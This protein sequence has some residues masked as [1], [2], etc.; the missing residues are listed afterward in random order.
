M[1]AFIVISADNRLHFLVDGIEKCRPRNPDV[2]TYISTGKI[3]CSESGEYTYSYTISGEVEK[4]EGKVSLAK[5]LSNQ[6]ARFRKVCSISKEE[7]VNVFLLENPLNEG[8]LEQ[9]KHWC[10]EFENIYEEGQGKDT[11]FRLFR[12]LFT[13]DVKN[14][15]D[16]TAQMRASLLKEILDNHHS[17]INEVNQGV[18]K[19]FDQFIFYIDNQNSDAAALC[20]DKDDHNL[21]MPR[22]LIDIMMLISNQNDSYG[23]MQAISNSCSTRCFAVGYAESMYYYPDVVRYFKIADYR[24][25][26]LKFLTGEDDKKDDNSRSIMD[27]NRFP[28]GVRER[29][30]R[31]G[32]LY[33]DVSFDENIDSYP[34]SADKAIDD[35]LVALKKE[36]KSERKKEYEDF[37]NSLP[38][39]ELKGEI[40][41]IQEQLKEMH[42]KGDESVS[43]FEDR[44]GELKT[45]LEKESSEL[46]K[47]RKEFAPQCPEYIDRKSILVGLGID[48]S[49]DEV[50]REKSSDYWKLVNYACSKHFLDYMESMEEDKGCSEPPISSEPATTTSSTSSSVK[51]NRRGCLGWLFFWKKENSLN[52][53]DM[54]KTSLV[55]EEKHVET[56]IDDKSL[57]L[58]IKDM[59]KC[60]KAFLNF[61][62]QVDNMEEEYL[63]NKKA[64]EE[65]ELTK[66]S[67]SYWPLINKEQLAIEQQNSF[68]Q[69]FESCRKEWTES[70]DPTQSS[71]RALMEQYSVNF[72]KQYS[73]INWDKP[74]PFIEELS[75]TKSL[76]KV[77]NELQKKAAPFANY[78]LVTD[79]QEN[80]VIR[81]LYS[82][83]PTICDDFDKMKSS[84]DN[85]TEISAYCS[86]HIE[87]KICMMQFLPMDEDVLEHLVDLH[88]SSS[89]QGED[90]S[91]VSKVVTDDDNNTTL[92]EA[93]SGEK[94]EAAN[95]EIDWGKH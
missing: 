20:L 84:L 92:S 44:K 67:N 1:A 42:M 34:E 10:S 85:G 11:G 15:T 57:I 54:P 78:N 87:S 52:S 90:I 43:Q 32:K 38:I 70:K 94:A 27:A 82:D 93:T 76:P 26:M 55:P 49:N 23:V 48:D 13:Y 6:F 17:S 19:M 33:A 81:K 86:S 62:A 21:K 28:F 22:Y 45:L 47:R 75:V 77:C 73:Y 61:V 95:D 30:E 59:L 4:N 88:D 66:H 8:D 50:L 36:L 41:N 14:P 58:K 65:F 74:F 16:V 83:I 40:S 79:K 24:D 39:V 72:T 3:V 80:K 53:D 68:L 31:L 89:S 60:K 91:G 9:E 18:K 2:E 37:E 7:P 25:L 35:S 63:Q 51:E 29:K 12:I 46:D 5:L 56:I 69:R 71:F 64:T